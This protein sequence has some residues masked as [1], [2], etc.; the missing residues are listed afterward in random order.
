[1]GKKKK[2]ELEAVEENKS[3]IN[4]EETN[5]VCVKVII[6]DYL[7]TVNEDLFIWLRQGNGIRAQ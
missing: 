7:E 5:S 1:M 2:K 4:I 3:E 6:D